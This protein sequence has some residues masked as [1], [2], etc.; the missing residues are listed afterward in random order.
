M[1]QKWINSVNFP[2]NMKKSLTGGYL[3]FLAGRQITAHATKYISA[4]LG[5]KEA[6][7]FLMN[8]NHPDV[9]SP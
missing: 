4:I 5:S 7:C 2:S 3:V 8:L 1:L 6:G 9:V